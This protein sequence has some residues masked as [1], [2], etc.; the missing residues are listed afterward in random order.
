MSGWL[1]VGAV[2]AALGAPRVG[3]LVVILATASAALIVAAVAPR[4]RG[5]GRV[6][7][8]C[9]LL[10]GCGLIAA[11]LVVAPPAAP[12]ASETP[13]GKGPWTAVVESIGAVRD[14]SQVATL[15]LIDSPGTRVAATLPRYPEI[16]PG[17][18][19]VVD[20]AVRAPPEGPYGD[21]LRRT[22]IAGTLQSR[23]LD[24]KGSEGGPEALLERLR[25]AAGAALTTA[26]PEPEAGLAAGIVVG[27]RD[28]VDRTLA[29]DFT[30][31]G[32]SHIV[33][34][35]G[36]N[37][38]IVA[39]SVAALAGSWARRRR[40]LLTAVAIVTYV[41]FAGASP[42][43][44]RAAAMAGVV[45]V[46]RESG[47]AGRAAA[48]LGWA[49]VILLLVDPALVSDAG[50]QLST[51][52]TAGILAWATPLN[53]ELRR[54]APARLPDWLV[55]CLAV[56]LAAQA[57]TLPLVLLVFG[58]LAI[59][60]PVINLAVVPIVAPA[61]A[62]AGIA[63]VGGLASM[64]GAPA[65]VA[66]ILGLPGWFLLS[67]MV[68]VVQAGARLPFASA[69]L[70]PPWNVVAAALAAAVPA[71]ILVARSRRIAGRHDTARVPPGARAV[72]TEP[73][74]VAT[75]RG[76]APQ[77]RHGTGRRSSRFERIVAIATAASVIALVIAFAH[78]QDGTTRIT[79]IDVGQGDSILVEGGRGGRLL[80][81]GGPDPD[82]LLIELDRRLPPW[83]RRLD[84]V[85]LT[86]PHEDHVAGLAM[87]L[88]RYRV[89]RVYETGM[90]GPGPG[91]KAWARALALPNAP[92][93]GRLAT[94]D[95]LAVDD[96]HL[97]VLWP[98]PGKVPLEPPDGGRG[99]NDVSVVLVGEVA[100]RRILLTGDVED[101][102]DP[103]LV[104]RGLPPIDVLKV[105]HHGS[106]TASTPA[107]L[108]V[109]KPAVAIV[110]AGAGNPYGHPARST[111]DRLASTGARVLRTDTDGSVEVDIGASGVHIAASGGRATAFVGRTGLVGRSAGGLP[112]G[113]SSVARAVPTNPATQGPA[114]VDAATP[115]EKPFRVAARTVVTYAFV[116]AV[117]SSG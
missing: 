105:A 33:A 107:F 55:E 96:L 67:V 85:I 22:G 71:A 24:I 29:A 31:V 17:L 75:G 18:D 12:I 81:D 11:R 50:F 42:S 95:R 86:H 27:L 106:K 45:L 8:A 25:R 21:Y 98:D 77:T 23:G 84:A 104:A 83:D 52:A 99:I 7:S 82:R 19:V 64:A 63:L 108:D 49:A 59:I 51:L 69:T 61:M 79:V 14:G 93:D 47:R 32:A 54:R 34:I 72:A 40:A 6:R 38:A 114:P 4:S 57:A 35:S 117:P 91:Y 68:G 28:R 73:A 110:S 1:A 5:A 111:L 103:L 87:L 44:V 56:S 66:T 41:V 65:L 39:A 94:G 20:G 15:R 101:D 97:R 115:Y 13:V 10:I 92:P 76:A 109:V 9:L 100:G 88:G 116:C 60:S 89:G 62:A 3:P 37:I 113:P 48:A 2:I 46:A 78:R 102:V 74:R 16:E 58:R 26:I 80:V 53:A 90:H 30:T 70:E 36:W 112:T 43:V